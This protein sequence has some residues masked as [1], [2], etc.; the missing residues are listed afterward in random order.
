VLESKWVQQW[1]DRWAMELGSRLEPWL[2]MGKVNKWAEELGYER[3]L[4]WVMELA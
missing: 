1:A 4:M 3:V 2:A